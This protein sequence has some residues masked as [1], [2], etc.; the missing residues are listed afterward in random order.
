MITCKF[1][2]HTQKYEKNVCKSCGEKFTLTDAEITERLL[3]LKELLSKK[4]YAEAVECH[5]ILADCGNTV[6]EREYAKLLE[7]NDPQMKSIDVAMEYYFRA[8][9]KNDPYSA[10]R[11]SRL[12]GRSSERA[13]AFWLKY[14]SVLGSINSY[15]DASEH[16][17]SIGREDVAAYY[18]A[19]AA[20]CDDTVSI[21]NMAKRWYDGV[22]VT[23]EPAHAKWYLDKL[24]IPP[25]NAIK[26]AYKLRSIE[27]EAPPKLTFPDFTKYVRQLADEARQLG[28]YTA[29]HYLISNLA[30]NGD[31]NAET[32]LGVLL[33]EG[34]GCE[35]DIKRGKATLELSVAHGNP[36]AAIYL[37]EG[38]LSGKFFQK[39]TAYAIA[40]YEKAAKLGYPDAYEKLG[41]IYREGTV[42]E[43]DVPRAIDLYDRAAAGGCDSAERKSAELKQK[44][45]EFY[46]DA[47]K[48]INL[49]RSVTPE[50][51]FSAFKASAIASA[52]GETRAMTLL[53]KCYFYGFG[54]K[55]DRQS[56]YF[57]FKEAATSG[58]REANIHL[59]LC[60]SRG[61]G[62][63]F[64][65]TDAV[66]YLKISKSLGLGGAHEELTLLYKR[67]MKKTVRALYAQSM[68]LLFQKK[69]TDA[70]KLLASF[71]SI[72]Y[73]KALYTLG[74]LYE[75]GKGVHTDPKRAS[76][77]YKRAYEG[78]TDFGNFADPKSEYKF[79]V[80]KLIR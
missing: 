79:N 63:A 20:G 68:E 27:A 35:Q 55:R 33:T 57:W 75:F 44:R 77:Y 2:K 65:F 28:F 52:M 34:C 24:T 41:D 76:A 59:A 42:A 13:S 18:C 15:P 48:I 56:G 61:L 25:I 78:N 54:T 53:G 73:P 43:R 66:K 45:Y 10:Y 5:H 46:L 3:L 26:L 12:I 67:R 49:T 4:K 32:A 58:D 38:H 47:Y 6:S 31:V 22:G 80:M 51:A 70:A 8:A 62:T 37:G 29:Y 36:A 74:C 23:R 16:F 7:K 14:A 1:C 39:D 50:E 69:Y 40:C 19:L 21:V 64:S 60:Y 9:K 17:S 72:G 11:F 71:E 30:K